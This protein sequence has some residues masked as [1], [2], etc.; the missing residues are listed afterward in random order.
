MGI[1]RLIYGRSAMQ[2]LYLN[3]DAWYEEHQITTWLNTRALSIDRE[4]APRV[5]SA[6][7]S[8]CPTTG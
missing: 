3:P 1:T 5:A 2:G 8:R 6:P 7:A 4:R